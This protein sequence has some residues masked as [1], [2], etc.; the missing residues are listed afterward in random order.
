MLNECRDE[1]GGDKQ[2][3]D[4]RHTVDGKHHDAKTK[5]SHGNS[6]QK[7]IIVNRGG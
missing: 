6:E 7:L 3:S 2:I 4:K 5:Q 1:H